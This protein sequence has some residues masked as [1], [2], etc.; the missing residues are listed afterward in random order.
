MVLSISSGWPITKWD[1]EFHRFDGSN[2]WNFRAL[3]MGN[4]INRLTEEVYGGAECV[5]GPLT[6]EL[7]MYFINFHHKLKTESGSKD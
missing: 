7:T 6:L 1:E 3:M 5:F 4:Y 2:G